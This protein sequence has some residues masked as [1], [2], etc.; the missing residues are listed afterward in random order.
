MAQTKE[1]LSESTADILLYVF[2]ALLVVGII[3][4]AV[5]VI[6]YETT[7]GVWTT[8]FVLSLGGFLSL[9]SAIVLIIVSLNW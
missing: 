8:W 1:F 9:G 2:V 3:L 7:G 6:L 5:S 4:T